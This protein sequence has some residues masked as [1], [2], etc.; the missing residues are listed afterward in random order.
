MP[1]LPEVETIMRRL[2]DG[3]PDSVPVT[4]KTIEAAS[5]YWQKII[6]QPTARQFIQ[7]L[8]QKTIT[9]VRRRGK[10]I[11]FPLSEGHLI[12]HLRMSGDMRMEKRIDANGV[13]LPKQPYDQVIVALDADWRMVLSSIRKFSRM[14]YVL[15]PQTVLGKLGPEPLGPNLNPQKLYTMLQA[16]HR[17]IK[18]L[19]MDQT[20][21]AGLGNIYTDEVLFAARIHPLRRSNTLSKAEAT[22]LYEAMQSILTQGIEKLGSSL[23]WMYR[24]GEFQNYFKVH[25]RE[26]EP[27]PGCGCTIK[28]ITV[29]QRSTYF[30]PCCQKTP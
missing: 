21:I 16:H 14:W 3:T 12:A 5:V 30:C 24:G 23:D 15:D 2:R 1:E 17:Q 9:A 8:Q 25:Q 28:K 26:G 18:P 22:A 6:E 27:C 4:G 11:H 7:D 20:F 13:P 19:L 10:F 29:G